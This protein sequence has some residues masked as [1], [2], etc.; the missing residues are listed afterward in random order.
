MRNNETNFARFKSWKC[1]VFWTL[2]SLNS[3]LIYSKH[4]NVFGLG[5]Y[6]RRFLCFFYIFLFDSIKILSHQLFYTF[7]HFLFLLAFLF[8]PSTFHVLFLAHPSLWFPV[9]LH[10]LL[11]NDREDRWR[12]D[13]NYHQ[14]C[15][16]GLHHLCTHTH[17]WW[18]GV[19][20]GQ[21]VCLVMG[22]CC[23]CVL[24]ATHD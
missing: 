8:F 5:V 1:G 23:F 4:S 11:G 21:P 10:H 13:H 22:C 18:T 19:P 2:K 16:V 15:C 24:S 12:P 6:R 20:A 9:P 17:R 3:A 7:H 14:S